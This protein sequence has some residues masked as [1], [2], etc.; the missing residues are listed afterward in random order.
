MR[1]LLDKFSQQTVADIVIEAIEEGGFS[2]EEAIPGLVS[3]ILDFAGLTA[4]PEQALDE[5]A[6]LLADGEV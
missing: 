5:A 4:D 2:P 6:N 3:A 1:A